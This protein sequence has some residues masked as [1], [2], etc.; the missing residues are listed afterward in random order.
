MY[1]IIS[2]EV[3][4]IWYVPFSNL[5][6]DEDLSALTQCAL[7]RSGQSDYKSVEVRDEKA[8]KR[9]IEEKL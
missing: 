2:L 3:H 8:Q 4:W 1:G 9:V 6:S 5:I 7:G